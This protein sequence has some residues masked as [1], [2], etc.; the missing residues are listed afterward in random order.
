MTL[1]IYAIK[2][3][4]SYYVGS[5]KNIESRTWVHFHNLKR[6]KHH[7]KELQKEYNKNE[8]LSIEK[9]HYWEILVLQEL[10]KDDNFC[11]FEQAW[12]SR[13]LYDGMW[14][15]NTNKTHVSKNKAAVIISPYKDY[16][17]TQ[18]EMAMKEL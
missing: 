5:S 12:I 4:N 7:C 10:T 9:Q 1:G 15:Y 8:K 14:I 2:Y 3:G 6:N 18:F 17:Q 13:L 16:F 11:D